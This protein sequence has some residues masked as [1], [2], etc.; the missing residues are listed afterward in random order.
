MEVVPGEQ[1]TGRGLE[2]G[3]HSGD[4]EISH[5]S[6]PGGP[7]NISL[8]HEND[9]PPPQTSRTQASQHHTQGHQAWPLLSRHQIRHHLKPQASSPL[10]PSPESP[11]HPTV[12]ILLPLHGPNRQGPVVWIPPATSKPEIK[13][14]VVLDSDLI[15]GPDVDPGLR[16][17]GPGEAPQGPTGCS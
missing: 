4:K 10:L 17:Q 16:G 5:E 1:R 12:L 9:L 8:R 14:P 6:G 2:P 7:P 3:D 11:G 13:G 15:S